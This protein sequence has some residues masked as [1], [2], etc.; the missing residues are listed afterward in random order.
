[1]YM[2]CFKL[3]Q[4]LKVIAN[5]ASTSNVNV[6]SINNSMVSGASSPSISLSNLTCD[7]FVSEEFFENIKEIFS[8]PRNE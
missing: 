8:A 1:M 2:M 7:Q 3:E 5:M 4:I 6:Q